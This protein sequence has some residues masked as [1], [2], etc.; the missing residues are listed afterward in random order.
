[1]KPLIVL[2]S[3]FVLS[4]IIIFLVQHQWDFILSGNIAMCL[5]LCFSAIGHFAFKDGMSRMMPAFIPFKKT[6]V[7][8]TGILEIV[9]GILLLLPQF[10]TVTG[11][12]ILVFLILI[13]PANI[14]AAKHHIDFDK[15]DQEG[16]GLSYLWFRV[17]LQLFFIGWVGMFSVWPMILM[18]L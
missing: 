11:W 10:R 14:Y 17:P 7:L 6:I 9:F 15:P 4:L 13:L 2:L 8:L 18:S 16:K 1:M 12:C 5:M 3:S